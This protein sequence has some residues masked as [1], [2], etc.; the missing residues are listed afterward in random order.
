MKDIFIKKN[1]ILRLFMSRV[2][3][4]NLDF[5][6]FTTNIFCTILFQMQCNV[7]ETFCKFTACFCF[8]FNKQLVETLPRKLSPFCFLYKYHPVH[9]FML[10]MQHFDKYALNF[11]WVFMFTIEIMMHVNTIQTLISLH[12]QCLIVSMRLVG[13]WQ[14]TKKWFTRTYNK[15][16]YHH[17]WSAQLAQL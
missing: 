9:F 11:H 14:T 8:F 10:H 5:N 4:A 2:G 3:S 6:E 7:F 15:T 1:F 12:M 16:T 17:I 13:V